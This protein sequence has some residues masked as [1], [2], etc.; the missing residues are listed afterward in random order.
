M[1]FQFEHMML[2]QQ[3]GKEKWDVCPL[4]FVALKQNLAKWQTKLHGCGW[5]SLFWN[6]HDLPRQ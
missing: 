6:N 4:P 3:P 1:V 5:N 2:D